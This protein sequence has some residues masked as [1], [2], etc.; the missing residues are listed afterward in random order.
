MPV[1]DNGEDENDD[2]DD[3]EPGGFQRKDMRNLGRLRF[4][5]PFWRG[6]GHVDIVAPNGC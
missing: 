2:S 1:T 4:G 3:D 6:A 5:L